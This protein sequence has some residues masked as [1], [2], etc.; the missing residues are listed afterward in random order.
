MSE[1][2]H[3]LGRGDGEIERGI[4]H[5]QNV[6]DADDDQ[7]L[8]DKA[9]DQGE[10]L[11]EI[12]AVEAPEQ[13]VSG[14][15]AGGAEK[16]GVDGLLHDEGECR[17]DEHEQERGADPAGD[18][19]HGPDVPG[20]GRLVPLGPLALDQLLGAEPGP[21]LGGVHAAQLPADRL[22]PDQRRPPTSRSRPDRSAGTRASDAESS[23]LSPRKTDHGDDQAEQAAGEHEQI[24][25][26]APVPDIERPSQA[27]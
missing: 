10:L 26:D 18:P 17:S 12:V 16:G 23:K 7:H 27:R 4:L 14:G 19:E 1:R 8:A 20:R 6:G 25:P 13:S 22:E 15:A 9:D 3:G 24:R 2:E 11:G 21:E 5:L